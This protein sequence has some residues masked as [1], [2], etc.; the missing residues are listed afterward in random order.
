MKAILRQLTKRPVSKRCLT[1]SGKQK[2]NGTIRGREMDKRKRKIRI[3]NRLIMG[4]VYL[5]VI[6]FV[7]SALCIDSESWIPTIVC[8]VCEAWLLF[9]LI[10][11][12][13]KKQKGEK[14]NV[15]NSVEK[16]DCNEFQR[17]EA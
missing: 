4:S 13:P 10:C 12:L 17:R 3:K 9:I 14:K 6:V 2:T 7:L 16:A 8:A 15:N 5:S 1:G 11:N